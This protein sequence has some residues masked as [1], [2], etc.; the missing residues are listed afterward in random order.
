MGL[1][2]LGGYDRIKAR[3]HRILHG[4]PSRLCYIMGG[5]PFG[6]RKLRS[7][8]SLLSRSCNII[9]HRERILSDMKHP[10]PRCAL[11][12]INGLGHLLIAGLLTI[13]PITSILLR[14]LWKDVTP[15]PPLRPR[16]FQHGS[17]IHRASQAR[18]IRTQLQLLVR[19]G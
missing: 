6:D 4:L 18:V 16:I 11:H 5:G 19:I 14:V 17:G 2:V 9:H 3:S 8:S 13:H 15:H 12:V 7:I 10:G 1:A